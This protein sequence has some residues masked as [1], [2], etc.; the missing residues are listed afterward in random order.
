MRAF[1]FD[2]TSGISSLMFTCTAAE[3]AGLIKQAQLVR[4]GLPQAVMFLGRAV[5]GRK[6]KTE[7]MGL[8]GKL[9]PLKP[10]SNR[11][12][13]QNKRSLIRRVKQ[14]QRGI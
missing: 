12:F 8:L 7:A 5:Q 6:L 1:K 10:D 2:W 4:R 3:A 14:L 11:S 9:A 13:T